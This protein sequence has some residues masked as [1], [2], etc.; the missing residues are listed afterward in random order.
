MVTHGLTVA[1]RHFDKIE[2]VED[3]K[4]AILFEK[5]R[6]AKA[7]TELRKLLGVRS[8]QHS[9]PRFRWCPGSVAYE[10]RYDGLFVMVHAQNG[11]ALLQ[12]SIEGEVWHL[13]L[14]KMT[15]PQAETINRDLVGAPGRAKLLFV[16]WT[17]G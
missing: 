12:Y 10:V 13:V 3:V 8:A 4:N 11:Y 2:S 5:Q 7:H 15:G 9:W 17:L 14:V 6:T 1:M 16:L